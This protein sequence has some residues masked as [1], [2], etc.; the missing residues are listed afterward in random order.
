[1]TRK[2]FERP[3]PSEIPD[4]PGVYLFKDRNGRVIYVGKALSLRSR[5]SSY[6]QDLGALM[7]RT[8]AMVESAADVEWIVVANE[9][10]SL[11]LE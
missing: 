3:K 10:E 6:F 8:A 9:V 5:V 11:H 1:M 2:T 7:A 4:Q